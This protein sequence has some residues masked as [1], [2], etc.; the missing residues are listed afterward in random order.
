MLGQNK[1]ALD[2]FRSALSSHSELEAAKEGLA[3]IMA[4]QQQPDDEGEERLS[5]RGWQ[6]RIRLS[7]MV[8]S[9][10]YSDDRVGLSARSGHRVRSET[11][12][13]KA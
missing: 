6:R 4:Q 3:R 7:A 1:Q 2:D 8:T 9:G 11:Q 12:G 13:Q 5:N 10:H